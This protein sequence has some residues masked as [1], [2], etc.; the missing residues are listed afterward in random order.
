[1]CSL[2]DAPSEVLEDIA[3]FAVFKQDAPLG[4]PNEWRALMLSCRAVHRSL[5][6][7][8]S[9]AHTLSRIF[10]VKFDLSAPRRRF[11]SE[12]F[13]S[14]SLELELRRRFRVL[15]WARTSSLSEAE[16]LEIFTTAYLMLLEDCGL[17]F[18]QLLWAKVPD[19]VE[20]Y[21]RDSSHFLGSRQPLDTPLDSFALVLLWRFMSER[22]AVVR[23]IHYL[24]IPL[25]NP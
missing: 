18:Q 19:L 3:V 11:P 1:M 17:N 10:G 4:P 6:D 22:K 2:H 9:K 15:G 8:S 5:N 12:K 16:L 20:R 21:L 14:T 7:R 25:Q 24:L 23:L 13:L